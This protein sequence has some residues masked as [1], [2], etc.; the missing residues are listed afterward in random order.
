MADSL[1]LALDMEDVGEPVSVDRATE[2]IYAWLAKDRSVLNAIDPSYNAPGRVQEG[3][4]KGTLTTPALA[5]L[6][7]KLATTMPDEMR[8]EKV[9]R[10]GDMRALLAQV[11][12]YGLNLDEELAV[13]DEI[14]T[15]RER[16]I[17][18]ALQIEK[19]LNLAERVKSELMAAGL[20]EEEAMVQADEWK[21]GYLDGTIKRLPVITG[22]VTG[23]GPDGQVLLS[24]DASEDLSNSAWEFDPTAAA[25]A[26]AAQIRYMSQADVI[27]LLQEDVSGDTGVRE[28]MASERGLNAE[29]EAAGIDVLGRPTQVALDAKEQSRRIYGLAPGLNGQ[30]SNQGGRGPTTVDVQKTYGL[31]EIARMPTQMSRA[32]VL[33][34]SKKLEKAGYYDL[35][36]SKPVQDG[37]PYDPTFKKAWQTLMGQSIESKTPMMQLLDDRMAA[38]QEM[39][40]ERLVTRLTDPARIRINTDAVGQSMLGRK[41][42]PDEHERMVQFVHDLERRNA[43]L[44]AGMDPDADEPD[45]EGTMADIDA[46]IE[47][48]MRNE[49]DTEASAK[50]VSDQYGVFTKLLSGPGRGI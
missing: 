45:A 42:R 2:I 44:E 26:E 1:T 12:S 31:S 25:D 7:R 14:F 36:G 19:S 4:K 11:S 34:I 49:N 30:A 16:Q 41:L 47:E 32:E 21:R 8:T 17:A 20:A 22:S 50:E 3:P 39:I 33:A 27:R 35:I 18:G 46:R 43:K 38:Q 40:D 9:L 48:Y 6:A 24:S 13:G 23:V 28:L 37:N 15:P 5:E 29:A 10:E